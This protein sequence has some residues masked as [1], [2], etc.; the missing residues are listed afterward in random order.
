MQGQH[1]L[2]TDGAHVYQKCQQGWTQ[3][4]SLCLTCLDPG[5]FADRSPWTPRRV[6]CEGFQGPPGAQRGFSAYSFKNYPLERKY[7]QMMMALF[8]ER[9]LRVSSELGGLE[10][11]II[12]KIDN[13]F[14]R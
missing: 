2:L 12:G 9:S 1:V 14:T 3:W 5:G 7:K 13:S 11:F 6:S 8:T 10:V 4:L